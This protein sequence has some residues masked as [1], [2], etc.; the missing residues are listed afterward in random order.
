MAFTKQEKEK[1]IAQYE[2]WIKDSQAVFVLEYSRLTMK[3][4]DA[5]RAKVRDAGGQLHV[6]KNTLMELALKNLGIQSQSLTGT[7]LCG[8]AFNDAA[9]LAKTFADATKNSDVLKLKLG[10]LSGQQI[11]SD[12]VK[13]LADLPPLP[14]MRAKLLGLIQT[15][16]GQ[17]VRTLAEPGRQVAYVV[18]AYSEKEAAPSAA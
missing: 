18:K 2:A 4:V 3:D 6:V 8:F 15:P 14:I 7:S 12:S 9:A 13:S 11:T 5:L 10:F 1:L 16:A 17:L